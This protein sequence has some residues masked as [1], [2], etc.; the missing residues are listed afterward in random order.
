MKSVKQQIRFTQENIA[1]NYLEK[2]FDLPAGQLLVRM[3]RP[4]AYYIINREIRRPRP[5]SEIIDKV[6]NETLKA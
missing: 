2:C 3:G 4:E 1:W 6:C 5:L